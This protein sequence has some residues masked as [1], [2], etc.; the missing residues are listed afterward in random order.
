M[1]SKQNNNNKLPY[2]FDILPMGGRSGTIS[3]KMAKALIVKFLKRERI[4]YE[5]MIECMLYHPML[6]NVNDVLNN[7]TIEGTFL[8]DCLYSSRRMFAWDRAQ[9]YH[10]ENIDKYWSILKDRWVKAIGYN[11]DIIVG[12]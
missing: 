3:Q 8:Y 7:M 2:P 11:Y 4:F 6:K 9:R 1:Q 10:I 12:K 5:M